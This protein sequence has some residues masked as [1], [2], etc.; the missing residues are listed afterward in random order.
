MERDPGSTP[1]LSPH[2]PVFG[3]S[4]ASP[5]RYNPALEDCTMSGEP[6]KQAVAENIRYDRR[7]SV[8][9]EEELDVYVKGE[10]KIWTDLQRPI[11]DYFWEKVRRNGDPDYVRGINRQNIV[12]GGTENHHGLRDEVELGTVLD[13][14][15]LLPV[16]RW[17]QSTGIEPFASAIGDFE[18]DEN[19]LLYLDR[20]CRGTTEEI[21]AF[22]ARLFE[23]LGR[24]L[25]EDEPFNPTWAVLWK[26][27]EAVLDKQPERWL[28]VLGIPKQ[29]PGR[30]L[31]VLRYR[32]RDTGTLVRPTLLDAGWN[33]YHFPS[34]PLL[35]PASG[36][37]PMN[38]RGQAGGLLREYVHSQIPHTIAHWEAGRKKIRRTERA[39]TCR[40]MEQRARHHQRLVDLYG[41][42]IREWLP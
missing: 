37:H 11:G 22:L 19:L 36:G 18:R 4:S 29:E 25:Q 16:Y 41:N 34:P 23:A 20:V 33:A 28:E 31:I 40:L 14:R 38:L 32:V 35:P 13:L 8:E 2:L 6:L 12:V 17:A 39:V 1:A 5:H 10:P 9:R 7:V 24:K 42:E 3:R 21:S 26:D 27:L 30:W 15:G